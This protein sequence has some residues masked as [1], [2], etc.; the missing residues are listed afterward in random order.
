M[1][2]TAG[3]SEQGSVEAEILR[4]AVEEFA[5][6]GYRGT[7]LIHVAE[8]I[9]LTRQAIYHYFPRKHDLLVAIMGSYFDGL[10]GGAEA[11]AATVQEPKPRFLAMLEAHFEW[12][13]ANPLSTTVILHEEGS[14]PPEL[15][16]AIQ[17]R[18]ERQ[19]DRFVAA[20]KDGV[21]A[22][23]FA[24][25]P[26][27]LVV[28]TLI[29]AGSWSYRWF[30]ADGKLSPGEYAAFAS[31]LLAEGFARKA[32]A[33]SSPARPRRRRASKPKAARPT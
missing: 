18:R 28:S 5:V 6:R 24:D 31:S 30:K 20:Y 32:A 15:A 4:A 23:V 29:G 17:K 1:A 19:Q 3:V 26:V 25:L 7:N 8:H 14:L 2:T 16:A 27:G 12:V 21:K 11:A 22:G 13:A 9:G 33:T 10:E